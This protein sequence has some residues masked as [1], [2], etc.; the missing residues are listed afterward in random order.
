MDGCA[1]EGHRGG[2]GGESILMGDDGKRRIVSFLFLFAFSTSLQT[3]RVFLCRLRFFRLDLLISLGPQ[4]P[5]KEGHERVHGSKR[6]GDVF[7]FFFGQRQ[8]SIIQW[9]KTNGKKRILLFPPSGFVFPSRYG[10][11]AQ[12]R[13]LCGRRCR[14][15]EQR[16]PCF[17]SFFSSFPTLLQSRSPTIGKKGAPVFL[18]PPLLQLST[19]HLQVIVDFTATW[20][21][22]C[23][24]IGP[25]FEELSAEFAEKAIVFLKVDVDANEK[26]AATCEVKAMPTFQVFV[27]G[28][29]KEELVGASKEKLRALVEKYA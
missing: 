8:S 7:F 29:K 18:N 5:K 13:G 2:E 3:L 10:H 14:D 24:M 4:K 20:C 6:G 12:R 26:V 11:G 17:C 27:G 15:R 16:G 25:Y 23:R 21:G 9:R 1:R 22:P 19:L 28:A